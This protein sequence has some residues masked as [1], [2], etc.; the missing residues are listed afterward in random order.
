MVRFSTNIF[1]CPNCYF[2]QIDKI[3][4]LKKG[5]ATKQMRESK[6]KQKERPT[7]MKKTTAGCSWMTQ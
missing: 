7:T 6:E 1:C 2:V 5:R 4:R 3:G